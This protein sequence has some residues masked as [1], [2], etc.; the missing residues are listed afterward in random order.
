[1]SIVKSLSVGNGDMFYIDH[2]VKRF[3]IIDCCNSNLIE[4]TWNRIISEIK[5]YADANEIVRFISTHPDDDHIAGLKQLDD[6]LQFINFYC[7]KNDATKAD[8]T[9]D[10]K[11]YC[12]LRDFEKKSY[13]LYK[14]SK[15]K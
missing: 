5:A 1:M 3:T 14:D 13:Y 12:E 8:I 15:R 6:V 9:E 7:V 11:R 2:N 4:K 10:F